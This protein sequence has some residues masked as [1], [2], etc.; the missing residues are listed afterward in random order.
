MQ[1]TANRKPAFLLDDASGGL[2]D[3]SQ[4]VIHVSIPKGHDTLPTDTFDG[5]ISHSATPGLRGGNEFTVDFLYHPTPFSHL[6]AIDLLDN[7]T[8]TYESGPKGSASGKPKL[9]GECCLVAF[10]LPENGTITATFIQT[11]TQSWEVF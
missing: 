10:N 7:T 9:T 1:N 6:V 3:L 4:W 8:L 2:V 11:G 5:S